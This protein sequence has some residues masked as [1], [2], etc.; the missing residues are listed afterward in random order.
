MSS[1]NNKRVYKYKLQ[2]QIL[3]LSLVNFIKRVLVKREKIVLIHT[4]LNK[5][6]YHKFV[7]FI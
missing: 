3:N 5:Q 4:T 1:N 7:N 6:N 2:L